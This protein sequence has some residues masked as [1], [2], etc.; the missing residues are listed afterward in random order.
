MSQPHPVGVGA[1]DSESS[2]SDEEKG[3]PKRRVAA[4][5]EREARN[6]FS[7][8]KARLAKEVADGRAIVDDAYY[9]MEWTKRQL[10]E[11][12]ADDSD[13]ERA[14]RALRE[15]SE[16]MNRF[17]ERKLL[18]DQMERVIVNSNPALKALHVAALEARTKQEEFIDAREQAIKVEDRT[19]AGGGR[20]L[21]AIYGDQLTKWQAA[22]DKYNKAIGKPENKQ[23]KTLH[24]LE[25]DRDKAHAAEEAARRAAAEK[26][27][28]VA[29][30]KYEDKKAAAAKAR[31]AYDALYEQLVS[32]GA[33]RIDRPS[34]EPKAEAIVPRYAKAVADLEAWQDSRA[35]VTLKDYE[36]EF[37]KHVLAYKP[38]STTKSTYSVWDELWFRKAFGDYLKKAPVSGIS[39]VPPWKRRIDDPADSDELSIIETL[40]T[41][42]PANP[43]AA[44]YLNSRTAGAVTVVGRP[45]NPRASIRSSETAWG[46]MRSE[47]DKKDARTRKAQDVAGALGSAAVQADI[48]EMERKDIDPTEG[49]LGMK[50]ANKWAPLVVHGGQLIPEAVD[51][52]KEM[53][54]VELEI[55][56]A[57]SA[58]SDDFK[59]W[60]AAGEPRERGRAARSAGSEGAGPSAPA[61]AAAKKKA[62]FYERTRGGKAKVGV[63]PKATKPTAMRQAAPAQVNPV[64]G[65]LPLSLREQERKQRALRFGAMLTRLGNFNARRRP[66]PASVQLL[67]NI[68][69]YLKAEPSTVWKTRS[70]TAPDGKQLQGN[71]YPE[72]D[73]VHCSWR[74][75]DDPPPP[76]PKKPLVDENGNPTEAGLFGD[77]AYEAYQLALQWAELAA[78]GQFSRAEEGKIRIFTSDDGSVGE[79]RLPPYAVCYDLLTRNMD[80]DAEL[81]EEFWPDQFDHVDRLLS[82]WK[83]HLDETTI[84]PPE[85][86]TDRAASKEWLAY[87]A[88]VL[89]QENAKLDANDPVWGEGD[90]NFVGDTAPPLVN[91]LDGGNFAMQSRPRRPDEPEALMDLY[92][93]DPPAE[94]W[95]WWDTTTDRFSPLVKGSEGRWVPFQWVEES[96]QPM[97]WD[98]DSDAY[99]EVGWVQADDDEFGDEEYDLEFGD[100][101]PID[102]EGRNVRLEGVLSEFAAEARSFPGP[103][104]V[105]R[106]WWPDPPFQ[107]S[108]RV[109]YPPGS[110]QLWGIR[111][112]N[113]GRFRLHPGTVVQLSR[114]RRLTTEQE[115]EAIQRVRERNAQLSLDSA[116]P[117]VPSID[118]ASPM[119]RVLVACWRDTEI[120]A[121]G[122]SLFARMLHDPNERPVRI[123]LAQLEP[124]A[125]AEYMRLR[126]SLRVP[127]S[128]LRMKEIGMLLSTTPA[129]KQLL[130]GY[131]SATGALW[132]EGEPPPADSADASLFWPMPKLNADFGTPDGARINYRQCFGLW[133]PLR[134]EWYYFPERRV[135]PI[136]TRTAPVHHG[137]GAATAPANGVYRPYHPEAR[138]HGGRAGDI[139]PPPEQR[140]DAAY[141]GTGLRPEMLDAVRNE[142]VE[143]RKEDSLFYGRDVGPLN[144][145]SA[146]GWGGKYL[147]PE[148]TEAT[149]LGGLSVEDV[150][151]PE[152]V[153]DSPG[154]NLLSRV[155][156]YTPNL[157][158]V[159]P[160]EMPD[161]AASFPPV[162][163]VDHLLGLPTPE[164]VPGLFWTGQE[165]LYGADGAFQTQAW[166]YA[167]WSVANA[168][169]VF[170]YRQQGPGRATQLQPSPLYSVSEAELDEDLIDEFN[171]RTPATEEQLA[172]AAAYAEQE[173]ARRRHMLLGGAD[174]ALP[175]LPDPGPALQRLREL[176]ERMALIEAPQ[177]SEG[178]ARPAFGERPPGAVSKEEEDEDVLSF[179]MAIP[180]GGAHNSL[181]YGG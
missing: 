120:A 117:R 124:S 133:D 17:V 63:S 166:P 130:E 135:V 128:R 79:L 116:E 91:E 108:P 22:K 178:S 39:T 95:E 60:K 173:A 84:R 25:D 127:I 72:P 150:L 5:R 152:Q 119:E 113:T 134:G 36:A 179:H 73:Y 102:L 90:P 107:A 50:F 105:L 77:K 48:A 160:V 83:T 168:C 175:P 54:L 85:P 35:A 51:I 49:T 46:P 74:E 43:S 174:A 52:V 181:F 87:Q 34:A 24:K 176:D 115:F 142:A 37:A 98:P 26:G 45:R 165:A 177:R 112:E 170:P 126:E 151:R 125:R 64:S 131:R 156:H 162:Y 137:L 75:L 111:D 109:E 62:A 169:V 155:V 18:H 153:V 31:Q 164:R 163:T 19:P 13:K 180:R 147:G 8:L 58:F 82:D 106:T 140:W 47:A 158:H 78:T 41:P 16:Q 15:A 53:H 149:P 3:Q 61:A 55:I 110:G 2:D 159:A 88:I 9:N 144:V 44:L 33:Q 7:K 157:R 154:Y 92:G 172:Y 145:I 99:R 4:V 132:V 57:R 6:P 139:H 136:D 123:D 21:W 68:V 11:G 10:A 80:I 148:K 143:Q 27:T 146:S 138:L 94:V 100:D 42:D 171:A 70:Y 122:A 118:A 141:A 14:F 1:D 66:R 103:D 104:G 93:N 28:D 96:W 67:S 30:K 97:V 129:A 69:A 29:R 32:S 38:D 167:I 56:K 81:L 101:S 12:L 20:S 114:K 76:P 86:R 40:T 71:P 161:S 23:W 59:A 121:A 65:A 89:A